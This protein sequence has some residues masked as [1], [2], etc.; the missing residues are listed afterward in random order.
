MAV[1]TERATNNICHMYSHFVQLLKKVME[2]NMNKVL[3]MSGT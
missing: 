3:N 2:D 1:G